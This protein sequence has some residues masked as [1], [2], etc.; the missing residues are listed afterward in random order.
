VA[1]LHEAL[2]RLHNFRE[3]DKELDSWLPVQFAVDPQPNS[4][5]P[6]HWHTQKG[7]GAIMQKNRGL[8]W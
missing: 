2:R 3:V 1:E 8:Q 4:Q 7:G 6:P 5:K